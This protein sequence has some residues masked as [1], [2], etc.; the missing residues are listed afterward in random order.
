MD[1]KDY[2]SSHHYPVTFNPVK[3]HLGYIMQQ[4]KEWQ[5]MEWP[6]IE[7]ELLLMG[8]NMLDLYYGSLSVSDILQECNHIFY[9]KRI[10]NSLQLSEW[11]SPYEYRKI[12]LSDSSVWVV[13][14]GTDNE[15]FIHIH[16]AKYSPFSIRARATTLKTVAA[17]K[18][19][20]TGI[21]KDSIFNINTVNQI[22]TGHL[23][24]SPVKTLVKNK[25][26]ARLWTIFSNTEV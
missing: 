16:P 21:K 14:K 9:T 17:L 23:N 24:L 12:T 20:A 7:R 8:N 4:I 15:R 10:I 1:E 5:K 19:E 13:K 6:A 26:I 25:G 3:H 18:T 2:I 11:L 22:R